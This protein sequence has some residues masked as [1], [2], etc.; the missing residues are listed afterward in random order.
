MTGVVW[1]SEVDGEWKWHSAHPSLKSPA[2]GLSTYY[3]YLEK[4]LVKNTTDRVNL[5]LQTGDFAYT[6]LGKCFRKHFDVHLQRLSWQYGTSASHDKVLTMAGRDGKSYHYILPSVYKLLHHLTNEKRDFA[7]V[8]RTY[9]RD[10]PNALSS[11]SNGI[12][13]THPGFTKPLNIKVCKNPGKINRKRNEFELLTC[14]WEDR[15]EVPGTLKR[16]EDIYH[17]LSSSQGIVGY[18]DDFLYWQK[19][20]YDHAAGKPMWIDPHDQRHHHIFFDDNFRADDED[21]IIDVRVFNNDNPRTS[22]SL[23]HSELVHLEDVF[24]V[25]ADLLQSINDEEY[26]I[27]KIETC[28]RNFENFRTSKLSDYL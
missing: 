22:R 19:K 24:L 17:H 18:V 15:G 9:G 23:E 27:H 28:E 3:K 6:A 1:G 8:I 11:L 14:S 7:V 26:F 2:P 25:Q 21:S 5:R 12:R 16:E 10:A 20:N 13:G 4:K